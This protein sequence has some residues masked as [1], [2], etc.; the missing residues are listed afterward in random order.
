MEQRNLGGSGL[1]VPPLCFGGNVFGWT[2]NQTE[3]FSLLDA[4]L[5][6]GYNFIDTADMYS[7]WVPGNVGG[8]SE[9]IIG[10][11]LKSR[12]VRDRVVI[13]TK[14][15]GSMGDG[16]NGLS[17]SYIK[18]RSEEH[19]SELQSLMRISYAVFCLKKKKT[20]KIHTS[21][22]MHTQQTPITT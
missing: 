21:T 20:H 10:H 16:K 2:A 14:V 15:G 6:A 17:A 7:N 11:W 12:G 8:E 4:L 3:S 1:K 18:T 5:D 9:A 22:T 19:T 13:A